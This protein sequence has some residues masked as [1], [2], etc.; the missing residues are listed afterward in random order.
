MRIET[1]DVRDRVRSDPTDVTRLAA[2]SRPVPRHATCPQ[3]GHRDTWYLLYRS[4]STTQ[5][6]SPSTALGSGV[7]ISNFLSPPRGDH[8]DAKAKT[9]THIILDS[10][11]VRSASRTVFIGSHSRTQLSPVPCCYAS[12]LPV[13]QS[14]GARYS[15]SEPRTR[16]K[17]RPKYYFGSTKLAAYPACQGHT[18][19][20]SAL[21]AR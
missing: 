4:G 10:S 6:S 1:R 16:A 17:S 21:P 3:T 20:T 7:A 11:F 9:R 5:L 8:A 18:L 2:G 14:H 13:P 19:S 15:R 12:R